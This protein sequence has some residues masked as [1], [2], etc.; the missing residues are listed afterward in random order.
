MRKELPNTYTEL[1]NGSLGIKARTPDNSII[2]YEIEAGKLVFTV[3]YRDKAGAL[4]KGLVKLRP[5]VCETT[6]LDTILPSDL[7]LFYVAALNCYTKLTTEELLDKAKKAK[8]PEIEDFLQ[9]NVLSTKHLSVVEHSGS[10][11]MIE[12]ISRACSHQIVRHRL[13]NYSQ[14]SQRYVDFAG[15][16]MEFP[17]IIP[18]SVRQN[19]KSVEYFLGGIKNAVESYM[20]LREQGAQPEDA[21]F[22]LPN[23]TATRIVMSGNQRVWLEMIPKRTCARAQWEVDMLVSGIAKKLWEELPGVFETVGP[24][25]STGKCDQGKRTCGHPLNNP[26]STFFE[27][28]NYPHDQLI[29]GMR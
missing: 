13:F 27:N 14:Q 17:F 28:I 16:E 18:P 25:C 4:K 19:P 20:Y 21:R 3:D 5:V 6:R 8:T 9:T 23:A 12:G 7:H 26:L 24:A 22:L 10:S 11:F 15:S 1:G 2:E 29:F